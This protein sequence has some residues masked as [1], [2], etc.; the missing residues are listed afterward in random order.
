MLH[1]W[2]RPTADLYRLSFYC[3]GEALY[4]NGEWCALTNCMVQGAA[5][6][7]LHME[8][9]DLAVEERVALLSA[10]TSMALACEPIRDF[11]STQAEALA[12]PSRKVSF[13]SQPDPV[14]AWNKQ[15]SQDSCSCRSSTDGCPPEL[16][17]A[18]L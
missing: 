17:A 2:H 14:E 11:I 6:K 1:K 10:L 3:A 18:A 9:L 7:L 8:Y 15:T 12:A 13:P 5:V 4:T 16:M